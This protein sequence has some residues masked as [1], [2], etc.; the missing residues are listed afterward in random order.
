MFIRIAVQIKGIEEVLSKETGS[1][2]RTEGQ[3]A[4]PR[5]S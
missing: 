3:S 2:L 4:L 1:Y 5:Q